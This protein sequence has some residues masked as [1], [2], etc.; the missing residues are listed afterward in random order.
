MR[1]SAPVKV[2][3][4]TTEDT[5]IDVGRRMRAAR[6]LAGYD[7]PRA[8]ADAIGER[9]FGEGV[10]RSIERGVRPLEPSEALA[11]AAACGLDPNFFYA[12]LSALAGRGA[13][14]EQMHEGGDPHTR[15]RLDEINDRLIDLRDDLVRSD[16]IVPRGQAATRVAQAAA[17]RRSSPQQPAR[18]APPH[19]SGQGRG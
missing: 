19:R 14:T 8:L 11:V 3:D 9:G 4:V 10:I 13:A 12:P 1:C 2:V 17:R 15:M 18:E 7:T 6:V 5:P 16:V